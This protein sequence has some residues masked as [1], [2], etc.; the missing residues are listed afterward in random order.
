MQQSDTLSRYVRVVA[1][2]AEDASDGGDHAEF[3]SKLRF[4]QPSL[5]WT[6]CHISECLQYSCVNW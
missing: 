6:Y 4:A 1:K 5:G 2:L 3:G